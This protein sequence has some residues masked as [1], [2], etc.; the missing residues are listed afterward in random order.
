VSTY[1]IYYVDWLLPLKLPW[2]SGYNVLEIKDYL[3]YL[4][5]RL[6]SRRISIC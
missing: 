4:N 5:V 2:D 6:A 1:R 3:E